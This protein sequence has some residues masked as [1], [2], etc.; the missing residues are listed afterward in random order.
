MAG[1]GYTYTVYVD[2]NFHI[3]PD[4]ER[5]KLGDFASLEETIAACKRLVDTFLEDETSVD[6][7]GAE[8]YRQYTSFGPDPFVMTDDPAAVEQ[9]F[10]AWDYAEERC[11][12]E[13]GKGRKA[14][15]SF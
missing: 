5:Y 10:S 1:S 11:Q 14:A 3:P 15:S 8:R 2:H 6:G 13:E 7:P 9:R 4:D 12:E